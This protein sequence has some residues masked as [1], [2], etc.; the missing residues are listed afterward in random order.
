MRMRAIE[1][2]LGGQSVNGIASFLK[3]HRGSVSR[4]L[5]TYRKL[6]KRGLRSRKAPG[7]ERK[8]DCRIH[9]RKLLSIV[10]KSADFYGFENQL[11]NCRRI[12]RVVKQEMDVSVSV[13]TIWRGLKKLELSSQKPERRAVEQDPVKRQKWL[14]QEWPK[15]KATAKKKKALIFFQDEAGIKLT[16]TVGRS[17]GPK[18]VRPIITVTGKRGGVC[19]MSAVSPNGK[20][21]FSIPRQRVNSD[22][23]IEFLGGL[24]QE[25]PR[26]H[27]IVIADQAS[28][29]TS[30]KTKAY[31]KQQKRLTLFYLPPY[32]P[33]YNPDEHTWDHLKNHALKA[34]SA[35]SSDELAR[36]TQRQLRQMSRKPELIRSFFHR[37]VSL[38]L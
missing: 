37:T 7:P 5:T 25:Y 18:G 24:L 19:T 36:E 2:H 15:I 3:L 20:L 10:K 9:G 35:T 1:A 14:E 16:P 32:S 21:F 30:K 26:R 4:W 27:I 33:D 22:I 8:L 11:W 12:Q 17:W 29:H 6:G 13:A 38:K 34:H 28:S 31:V 23:F